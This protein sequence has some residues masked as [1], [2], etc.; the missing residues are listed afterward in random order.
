MARQTERPAT[1]LARAL[2][3]LQRGQSLWIGSEPGHLDADGAESLA[4][5]AGDLQML[6]G[7]RAAAVISDRDG[8]CLAATGWRGREADQ[9]ASLAA[10][11]PV[12]SDTVARWWFSLGE[13][14]IAAT[15]SLDP[16]SAAW[17]RIARRLLHAG[18]PL[19]SRVRG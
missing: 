13:F 16:R 15:G 7:G 11:G 1:E 4:G 17:V 8:L 6:V 19:A 14:T 2:F 3:Q 10:T 18:G 9:A 12:A 5:L